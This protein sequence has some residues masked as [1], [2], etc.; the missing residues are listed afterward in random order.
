M[1]TFSIIHENLIV[2]NLLIF[3]IGLLIGSFLNVLIYRLPLMLHQKWTHECKSFLHI[4]FDNNNNN[5]D[6]RNKN[7]NY[8]NLRFNLCFPASHCPQCNNKIPW[9]LNIPL[10]SYIFLHGKCLECKKTIHWHYPFIEVL[11]AIISVWIIYHYSFNIKAVAV[12]ILTYSLISLAFIDLKHYLLPDEITQPMLW[13]GILVNLNSWFATSLN[14][15]IYGTIIGYTSLWTINYLFELMRKK[16]G[17][18]N[19]DFKLFALF[20]AWLGWQFLPIILFM[21]SILG[22]LAFAVKYLTKKNNGNSQQQIAF[23]P[24]LIISGWIMFFIPRFLC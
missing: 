9:Y 4:N 6:N 23:G 11:T 19:G 13:L 7:H 8:Y 18:G 3:I 10:F 22:T 21:A 17:M 24:Y 15:A 2:Q 14:D 12:L 16:T 1:L 20:G 5:N